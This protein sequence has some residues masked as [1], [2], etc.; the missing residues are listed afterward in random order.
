MVHEVLIEKGTKTE[1]EAIEEAKKIVASIR[2]IKKWKFKSIS[3]KWSE[4]QILDE[5]GNVTDVVR[6]KEYYSVLFDVEWW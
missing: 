2:T 6:D 5:K 4:K 3:T 1:D